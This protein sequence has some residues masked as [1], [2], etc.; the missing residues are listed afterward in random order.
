MT[1][2]DLLDC[3]DALRADAAECNRELEAVLTDGRE[4]K[5]YFANTLRLLISG[6]KRI[7]DIARA[8]NLTQNAINVSIYKMMAL[9]LVSRSGRGV[10][11]ITPAGLAYLEART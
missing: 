11:A 5:G 8:R 9:G 1:E 2:A 4:S 7:A 10:Y 6:E 3:M